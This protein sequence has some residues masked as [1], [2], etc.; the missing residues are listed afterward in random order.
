MN[1]KSGVQKRFG[2]DRVVVREETPE[3]EDAVAFFER[4]PE[5][6]GR[7]KGLLRLNL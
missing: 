3:F 7:R 2:F 1:S 6:P 4:V 5:K